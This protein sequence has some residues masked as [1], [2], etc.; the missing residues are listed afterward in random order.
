M[1]QEF[2]KGDR[3]ECFGNEGTVSDVC[4]DGSLFVTFDR[5]S[6]GVNDGDCV[7]LEPEPVTI[8]EEVQAMMNMLVSMG[9]DKPRLLSRQVAQ[10]LSETKGRLSRSERL[11]AAA[12]L[13]VA[14]YVPPER[15]QEELEG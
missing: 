6:E 15:T 5:V 3:V 1:A 2:K 7:L 12:M 10:L 11:Q 9:Q 8:V 4:D 14:C 13:L